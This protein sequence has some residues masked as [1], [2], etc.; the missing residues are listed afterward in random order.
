MIQFLQK[1][2]LVLIILCNKFET[3][4]VVSLCENCGSLVLFNKYM[5]IPNILVSYPDDDR[6]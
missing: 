4:C 6:D 1:N 2:Y 3:F 5:F